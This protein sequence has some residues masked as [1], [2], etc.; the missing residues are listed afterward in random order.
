M[1]NGVSV[2][3]EA[4][5]SNSSNGVNEFVRSI[6][7]SLPRSDQRRWAEIY[8]RGLLTVQ[9]KKTIRRMIDGTLGLEPSTASQSLQQFISQSTWDWYQMREL[10]ARNIQRRLDPKA[11]VVNQS[12]VPKRGKHSVGVSHKFISSLGRTINCQVGIG[13]FLAT[14]SGSVPIDWSL[15]L[16][17]TWTGDKGRRSRAKIPDDVVGRTDSAHI[18]SMVDR[19]LGAWALPT[20]PIVAQ[21][22]DCPDAFDLLSGLAERGLDFLVEVPASLEVLEQGTP[23]GVPAVDP[24]RS[25]PVQGE[26]TIAKKAIGVR[27]GQPHVA[28]LMR[29][30]GE[31]QCVYLRCSLVQ[32]PGVRVS[33]AL[34]PPVYRLCGQWSPTEGRPTRY[35]VT[36]ML[37]QRP[38]EL[39]HLSSLGRCSAADLRHMEDS[40]GVKDFEGRSYPGWHRHMT[41]V[42]AAY[43]YHRLKQMASV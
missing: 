9:G 26:V 40:F 38:D 25:G 10:L 29:S 32:L 15:A 14:N 22:S 43:T 5:I 12:I 13:L 24:V 8:F 6:F 16:D 36:N 33:A 23:E 1:G 34:Q 41:L 27:T 11:W 19:A 18:F 35:W 3:E 42:S 2:L 39:M 28:T 4:R 31:A 37:H 21:I 17:D 30:S 7:M 20:A